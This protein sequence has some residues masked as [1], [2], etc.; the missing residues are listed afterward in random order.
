MPKKKKTFLNPFLLLQ[1]YHS[2]NPIKNCIQQHVNIATDKAVTPVKS[3][4]T[5]Y[6][7]ITKQTNIST[8]NLL[9]QI[10]SITL[11]DVN[12]IFTNIYLC[13]HKIIHKDK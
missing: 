10:Y 8:K 1:K 9:I 13:M 3:T 6:C 12:N 4:D 5:I 2:Q 7:K 11:N